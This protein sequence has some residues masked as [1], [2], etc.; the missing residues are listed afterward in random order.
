[1]IIMRLNNRRYI[2]CY[3][4]LYYDDSIIFDL[5]FYYVSFLIMYFTVF[6][7]IKEVYKEHYPIL[8]KISI[9]KNKIKN[10]RIFRIT[11]LHLIFVGQ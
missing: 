4:I 6:E 5:Y 8:I 3:F 11:N 2:L 9:G 10:I 1:M 7:S